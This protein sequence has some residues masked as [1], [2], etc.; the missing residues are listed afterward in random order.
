MLLQ[1]NKDAPM[2]RIIRVDLKDPSKV[3]EIIAEQPRN[4]LDWVTPLPGNRL[5]VAYLEDVKVDFK[6]KL[7]YFIISPPCTFMMSQA[8]VFT[9][10]LFPLEVYQEFLLR[11]LLMRSS[12]S[13]NPILFLE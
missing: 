10:F 13:S 4:K 2:F 3:S 8:S 11:K 9:K 6:K 7:N 5:L 12:I 1:T